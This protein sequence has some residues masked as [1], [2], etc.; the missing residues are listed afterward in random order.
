MLAF[1]SSTGYPRSRITVQIS[2][3]AADTASV[4]VSTNRSCTAAQTPRYLAYGS[5][6]SSPML[7]AWTRCCRAASSAP[8]FFLLPSSWAR[9]SDSGPNWRRIRARLSSPEA[10]TIA[11]TTTMTAMMMPM[12]TPVDMMTSVRCWNRT[13]N[14]PRWA[15]LNDETPYRAGSRARS[16]G[17]VVPDRVQRPDERLAFAGGQ[18]RQG[19]LGELV[20]I[21]RDGVLQRLATLGEPEPDQPAI[22]RV[23]LTAKQAGRLHSGRRPRHRGGGQPEPVGDLA[24]RQ[25]VLGPQAAQDDLLPLVHAMPGEGRPGRGRQRML[26][27]PESP[28]EVIARRLTAPHRPASWRPRGARLLVSAVDAGG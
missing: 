4:G 9:R 12:I 13:S 22:A 5:A 27:R 24:R 8:A 19:P 2:V 26:G 6:E 16:P 21:G 28:L 11:A 7:S 25:L 17:E 3:L 20:R 15:E 14:S 1:L 23:R 18:R 10:T